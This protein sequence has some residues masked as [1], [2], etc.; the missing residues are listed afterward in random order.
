MVLLSV[1]FSETLGSTNTGVTIP[2]ISISPENSLLLVAEVPKGVSARVVNCVDVN[3]CSYPYC[4]GTSMTTPHV[5][6]AAAT[7]WNAVLQASAAGVRSAL[8]STATDLGV[9][10]RDDGCGFGFISLPHASN[11]IL[12]NPNGCLTCAKKAGC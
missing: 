9:V 2:A 6:A 1:D 11:Q 5:A 3:R 7:L 10:G 12:R 4:D 8:E